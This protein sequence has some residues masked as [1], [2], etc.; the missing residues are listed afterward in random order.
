MKLEEQETWGTLR[1]GVDFAQCDCPG[2]EWGKKGLHL[3]AS[4][5]LLLLYIPQGIQL[6]AIHSSCRHVSLAIF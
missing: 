2:I 1:L 5:L 6:E 4:R 3:M